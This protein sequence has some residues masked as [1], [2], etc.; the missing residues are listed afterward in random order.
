VLRSFLD[1][2]LRSAEL[3]RAAITLQLTYPYAAAEI[4][5]A[6]SSSRP[7][8]SLGLGNESTLSRSPSGG[9]LRSLRSLR[10]GDRPTRDVGPRRITDERAPASQL[11]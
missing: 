6:P 5:N 7:R 8:T 10:R 4:A 2:L 3:G 1:T 9:R 11:W